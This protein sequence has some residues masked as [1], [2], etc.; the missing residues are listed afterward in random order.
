MTAWHWL[1]AAAAVAASGWIL[2]RGLLAAER[3][4]W[5][6]YR[7]R[8]ASPGTAASAALEVHALLEPW[9]RH[10]AEERRAVRHEDD[11]Q[12]EPPPRSR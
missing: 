4:G 5:I 11:G 7:K 3:R 10:E 12:G 2:D 9:R 8:R 1:G 6:F